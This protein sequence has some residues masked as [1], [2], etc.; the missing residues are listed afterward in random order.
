MPD[1]S[2]MRRAHD[3]SQVMA[4]IVT[5]PGKESS[6][7]HAFSRFFA[8]LYGVDED[9]VT[10]EAKCVLPV[11]SNVKSVNSKRQNGQSTSKCIILVPIELIL[12]APNIVV[13][14]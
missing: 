10:G 1:Y 7:Y 2:G 6:S 4:V 8:P 3:G 5:V 14:K 12:V 9:P 13:T 11:M